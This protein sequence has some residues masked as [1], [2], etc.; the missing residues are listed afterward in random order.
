MK[1]ITF[2]FG[3]L[4]PP[5]TGHELLIK[6]V[7]EIAGSSEHRIFVSSTSDPKKNPLSFERK[8]FWLKKMFSRYNISSDASLKTI[9]QILE[10]LEKDGYTDVTLVVG[11]DRVS[12]FQ[13]VI[14]PYV[15]RIDSVKSITLNN[16]QIV[17]AGE[18]DPDADDVTGMSASKLRGFVKENQFTN[19]EKGIPNTLTYQEK[20]A[21]FIEI[22]K[23]M[24]IK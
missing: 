11:S 5:S 14:F 23:A 21:L 18:R 1:K 6:K 3:R 24:G 8:V 4:N 7:K 20:Y 15:N 19:F 9:F 10:R 22:K 13:R 16:F 2:T 17:S 12:E